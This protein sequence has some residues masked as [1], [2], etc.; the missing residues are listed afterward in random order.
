MDLKVAGMELK[1]RGYGR[2][3]MF[4]QSG[5]QRLA[6]YA[7]SEFVAMPNTIDP[8]DITGIMKT[9][10]A[11]ILVVDINTISMVAP[12]FQKSFDVQQYE[13]IEL[14][15]RAKKPSYHLVVYRLKELQ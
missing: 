5:L 3:V 2:S 7:D 6:F 1:E 4:V 11:S 9:N 10:R 15:K 13:Q 8:R 12:G 14:K